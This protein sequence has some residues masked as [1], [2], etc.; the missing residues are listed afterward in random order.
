M[1]NTVKVV[2]IVI[3]VIVILYLLFGNKQKCVKQFE[4]FQ[5]DVEGAALM[6]KS[7]PQLNPSTW[8]NYLNQWT[9]NNTGTQSTPLL[10]APTNGDTWSSVKEA[11][12][13]VWNEVEQGVN[14]LGNEIDQSLNNGSAVQNGNAWMQNM[15]SSVKNLGKEVEGAWKRWSEG[16]SMPSLTAGEVGAAT[17]GAGTVA[18]VKTCDRLSKGDQNS[19]QFKVCKNLFPQR[20]GNK[21][22]VATNP[23]TTVPPSVDGVPIETFAP[24]GGTMDSVLSYGDYAPYDSINGFGGITVSNEGTVVDNGGVALG[25]NIDQY[26]GSMNNAF[27]RNLNG[28]GDIVIGDGSVAESSSD[29]VSSY[30]GSMNDAFYR[31]LN[32]RGD[33]VIGDGSPLESPGSTVSSYVGSMNNAFYRNLNGRGDIVIGDGP[34][35]PAGSS[36]LSASVVGPMNNSVYRN[37]NGRGDITIGPSGLPVVKKNVQLNRANL[38]KLK[39][40]GDWRNWVGTSGP[41]DFM[42]GSIVGMSQ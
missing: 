3:I 7:D 37:L 9:R 40:S 36:D 26:V 16:L 19:T 8:Q 39:A 27:Y 12:Q 38:N 34:I 20:Y 14:N 29:T 15:D 1:D 10:E 13:N 17:L 28:R 32:G 41:N 25:G 11:G 4:V 22:N 24:F 42:S 23:N 6:A 30:V 33:I 5:G 35:V 21:K 2:I 18:A 31:N